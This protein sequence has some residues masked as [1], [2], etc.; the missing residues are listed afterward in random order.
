MEAAN[1]QGSLLV[2]HQCSEIPLVIKREEIIAL[3][4]S[5]SKHNLVRY[6]I[7]PSAVMDA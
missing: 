6:L 1:L 2:S 3:Y 5:L 7:S 4:D